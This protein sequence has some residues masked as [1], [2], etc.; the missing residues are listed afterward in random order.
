VQPARQSGGLHLKDA[1]AALPKL[2]AKRAAQGMH[3]DVNVCLEPGYHYG[4][5]EMEGSAYSAPEGSR[6]VWRRAPV[7]GHE[8]AVMTGGAQVTNWVQTTLGGSTV[9]AAPVPA[10]LAP[11]TVARV[12]WVGGQRANRTVLEPESVLGTMTA[13]AASDGSSVGF[14]T[15]NDIPAAW[16]ANGTTAIEM[17]WPV[18]I[19]NWIEPRCTVASIDA[20]S[21]N[22][23]LVSPCG[24]F[25]YQRASGKVPAPPFIEA[26]PV[27]PLQP[28][29]FYHSQE[30]QMLYYSLAAGQSIDDLENSAWIGVKE[31]ILTYTNTANQ[32]WQGI[33]FLYSMWNEVNSPDGYVDDQTAVYDCTPG[34]SPWCGAPGALAVPEAVRSGISTGV[35]TSSAEP[36]GS[37][38]VFNSTNIAFSNCT[39]AAMGSPYGLSI[40]YGSQ[41]VN[42][43]GSTFHDLSG[44]FLKIGGVTATGAT[45]PDASNWDSFY[46]VEQNV[47]FDMA[48]EF[49]GAAGL[50][51]GYLWQSSITQNTITDSGY[52]GISEGWGWG[53]VFPPGAGNN[54]ISGNHMRNVMKAARDGG[55][56]YVNGHQSANGTIT[57]NFVEL[58]Q[59]VF[60]VVYLDNGASLWLVDSNVVTTS[61]LAWAFFMQG[62][63]NLPALDS[64]TQNFWWQ[65]TLAPVNNCEAEGCTVDWNTVYN[66]TAGSPWPPAAQAI[67]DA[68][69]ATGAPQRIAEA[70]ARALHRG[71]LLQA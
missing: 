19:A 11:F 58:D 17:R 44:G 1:V 34:A 54:T 39:F 2:L 9:Y 43:S 32:A 13:W 23:T 21:R 29:Q 48:L 28:G 7:G 35:P 14:T 49:R 69:G 64:H 15:A 65:Q 68:A 38:R 31:S 16:L 36:L 22:I 12:L 42:V 33:S 53:T 66:L 24:A 70:R 59:A 71:Q 52:S 51:A 18:V 61:P 57:R 46:T 63:C 37:V 67:V 5:I 8:E 41:N 50:F 45:S 40:S 56:I 30:S 25:L 4:G 3:G 20:A 62:C 27:F 10:A 55:G 6:V 60:A 47:A 26:A